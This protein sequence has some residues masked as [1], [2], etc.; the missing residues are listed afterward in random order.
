VRSPCRALVALIGV[1]LGCGG[2]A[3][4]PGG[5]T[6]P[7][8]TPTPGSASACSAA[9]VSG[10]PVLQALRLAAG[11]QS[12]VDVQAIAGDR[13]RLFVVEQPGRIRLLRDGT[14]AVALDITDR[15][16]AGG[17]RGL[18]GLAFHPDAARNGRLFVNYTDRGGDTRL[19]EFRLAGDTIDPGSER[20][21]LVVEQPFANHN[22]GALAFGRD[23]FLHVALGDG[24][25]G[26]DPR[27]FAQNLESLLGKVLRLDVDGPAPYA[28][29]A[30]NPFVSRAGARPEIWAFGLRNPWRISIDGASGDLWIG[31]VGQG[32]RE[33]VNVSPAG[34]GG[35]NFGWNV[36][37]GTLC[38][39][40]AAGCDTTGL[41]LPVL[42][43]ATRGEGCAVTGGFVYRG[44]RMPAL[45]GHYFYAD[46]CSAFVRSFRLDGGAAVDRRD[47][48]AQLRGITSPTSFGVDAEGELLVVDHDGELYKLIP[49]S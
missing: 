43:Y 31:D 15:V 45:Q 21:L 35:L 30:S 27:G 19:A 34:R 26:G 42:E 40:P 6:A 46:Y 41:T 44:C 18:L 12:P 22:G 9:P 7:A 10:V 11:L 36:T 3:P 39:S 1:A 23:G 48:T 4:T 38:F 49:A 37:E 24:G 5:G 17:E 20:T 2:S 8:A 29:P 33:E 47:W 13:A 14:L 28:I 16:G 25:S 32:S